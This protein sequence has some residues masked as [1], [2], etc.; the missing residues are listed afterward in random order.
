MPPLEEEGSW[1]LTLPPD[2]MVDLC[3]ASW[4]F[5]NVHLIVSSVLVLWMHFYSLRMLCSTA[6]VADDTNY[7]E[8]LAPPSGRLVVVDSGAFAFHGGEQQQ[9]RTFV[10]FTGPPCKLD[11]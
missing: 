7:V 8:G 1:P 2:F 5:G 11:M 9:R 6:S 4:A 3:S 10:P